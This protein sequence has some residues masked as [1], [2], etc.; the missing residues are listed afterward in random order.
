M[1]GETYTNKMNDIMTEAATKWWK[2]L[3][4][5]EILAYL[6]DQPDITADVLRE[7]LSNNSCVLQFGVKFDVAN[8]GAQAAFSSTN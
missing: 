1:N 7:I 6:A 8:L 3:S 5:D 2:G 4:K